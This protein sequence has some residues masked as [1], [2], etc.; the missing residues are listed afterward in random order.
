VDRDSDGF[1]DTIYFGNVAGHLFKTDISSA[2]PAQW[3]TYQLY[4]KEGLHSAPQASTTIDSISGNILTLDTG[5]TGFN[6]HRNVFGLTSK[7]M[8]TIDAV[9][10]VKSNIVTVSTV[11]PS[12]FVAGETL[13]IPSYDPIYLAPAV[14]FDKGFNLWVA[15]GSGDRTRSRTNPDSGKFMALR[16]GTTTVS[17]STVQKTDIL[18]S[19]LVP[20][21]WTGLTMDPTDIKVDGKWGWQFT[22]PMFGNGEKLFD[23]EPIVLPDLNLIPHIY[24]NTYQPSTEETSSE[25]DAPKNG[26]MYY[27]DLACDYGGAGT[28]G[29]YYESGRIAGGGVF[30]GTDY[31]IYQGQGEVASIPPLQDIKPIKLIYTGSLLF[32]KE[33]KR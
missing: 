26:I 33:K 31:I 16:D 27:Y 19:D 3:K 8:G 15:F 21:T 7:A 6:I 30:Q 23:P 17:A 1:L 2:N 13:V 9:D 14:F 11:S 5:A 25:C 29:G 24:F 10:S 20:L 12:S 4:K 32:Y 18:L 28:V 22:F